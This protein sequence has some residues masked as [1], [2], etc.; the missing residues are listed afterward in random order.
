[1]NTVKELNKMLENSEITAE[2][3]VKESINTIRT[4]NPKLNALGDLNHHAVIEAKALDLEQS[5]TGR[6]S[7]LHGIPILI[8]DNIL[9][10]DSMRT[11]VNARAFKNFYAP[12]D[13][14]LVKK[15]REA[16]AIILAKASL[17][18][19]AYY[20]SNTT[21]PSGYGSLFKQVIHP[22]DKALDPLG[23]STG[24]AVGVAAGFAPISIGTETNGSL[25]SPAT[26][27]SIVSIKPTVGL[28]SRYGIFPVSSLQDTAG[29]MAQ[30]VKDCAIGLDIIKGKD[31]HDAFTRMQPSENESYSEACEGSIKG[32][33]IGLLNFKSHDAKDEEKALQQ[34][35]VR[36]L[37]AEGATVKNIIHPYD[38]PDNTK[39]LSPEFKRDM[40]VFLQTIRSHT[41]IHSLSDLINENFSTSKLNLKHGQGRFIEAQGA[42]IRL[43]DEAYLNAKAQTEKSIDNF[44]TL[45]KTHDV[46]VLMTSKITG[47]APVGGMP[48][49]TVPAKALT[50]KKPIS[51]VFIGK[52]FSEA[53]LCNIASSYEAKTAKRIPPKLN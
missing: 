20:M 38:L 32:L 14:T 6:R 15:L 49:I 26:A 41:D 30:T 33:K 23:S 43:H 34:E 39:T 50:D 16:G 2:A 27:N 8:K 52:H 13:A 19:F 47:Y 51:M 3:L 53:L 18:E 9:T 22:Y 37:E 24:S 44:L 29:P 46:D 35:A 28:V 31:D 25:I 11:T 40:N 7:L 4:H 48:V 1:M 42:D 5:L 45:F 36:V 10:H 21:M 17:S 12:Y